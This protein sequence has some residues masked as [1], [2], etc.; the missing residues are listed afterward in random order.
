[1]R[2]ARWRCKEWK[3]WTGMPWKGKL[4]DG[5]AGAGGRVEK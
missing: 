5:T 4:S 3:D 1:M 2:S